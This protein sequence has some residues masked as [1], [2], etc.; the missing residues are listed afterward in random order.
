M[1]SRL[2]LPLAAYSDY[3]LEFLSSRVPGWGPGSRLN[4]RD[5][6]IMTAGLPDPVMVAIYE[7][8]ERPTCPYIPG[9][10]DC[11]NFARLYAARAAE[12]WGR[13]MVRRPVGDD[14]FLL[15]QGVIYGRLPIGDL[16]LGNHAANFFWNDKNQFRVWEPQRRQLLTGDDVARIAATWELEFH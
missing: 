11:E 4:R 6:D 10:F 2:A 13:I 15:A 8:I 5:R 7:A 16:E 12:L 9:V 1:T 3:G 14:L